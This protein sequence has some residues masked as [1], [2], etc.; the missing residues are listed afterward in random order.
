[1]INEQDLEKVAVLARLSVSPEE[2]QTYLKQM[3]AILDYFDQVSEVKTEGVDPLVTPTQ[4]EEF[5]REDEVRETLEAEK[6]LANAPEK[7]GHL[8]KVPPVV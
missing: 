2:S 6:A 4:I 1:M 8:F 3:S 7:V 5:W